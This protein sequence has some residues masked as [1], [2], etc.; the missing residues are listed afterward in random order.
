M[1]V[2][3][4]GFLSNAT[5]FFASVAETSKRK[6]SR[7]YGQVPHSQK[8]AGSISGPPR[9]LYVDIAF[10]LCLCGFSPASSHNQKPAML[11]GFLAAPN[12]SGWLF[13]SSRWT[14]AV[15][16]WVGDLSVMV[17]MG[18]SKPAMGNRWMDGIILRHFASKL[19]WS[20]TGLLNCLFLSFLSADFPLECVF[21]SKPPRLL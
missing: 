12:K 16:D 13:V 17:M 4:E 2:W 5:A 10:F 14:L 21:T 1:Q 19:S 18:S 11:I 15:M 9:A 3:S 7:W 8:V 20:S 6:V